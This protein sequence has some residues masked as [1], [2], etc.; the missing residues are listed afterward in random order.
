MFQ[1][2]RR[3]LEVEV[4]ARPWLD[5]A[6]SLYEKRAI[7][8]DELCYFAELF[9]ECLLGDP[10]G[11]AELRRIGREM[12]AVERAH[13]LE[14]DEAWYIDEAP[15]D[16]RALNDEWESRARA[17][18]AAAFRDAGLT[19][20]ADMHMSSSDEYEERSSAGQDKVFGESAD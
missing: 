18:V 4:N 6:R 1:R 3:D 12:Q 5:A 13:G 10:E 16:W 11:D 8:L 14:E 19:E 17:A 20:L 7:D 2:I 15:T 9:T